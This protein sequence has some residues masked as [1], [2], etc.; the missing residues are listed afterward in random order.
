M[1]PKT[2]KSP[3][4][5]TAKKTG[6]RLPKEP[7]KGSRSSVPPDAVKRLA[8]LGH[9]DPNA[10]HDIVSD[11]QGAA[12]WRISALIGVSSSLESAEIWTGADGGRIGVFAETRSALGHASGEVVEPRGIR[13][14]PEKFGEDRQV[15]VQ[16]PHRREPRQGLH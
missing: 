6:A 7:P 5:P 10:Y 11:A 1:A 14:R 8:D 4:P 12:E 16:G 3:T 13:R 9:V 15:V 2:K